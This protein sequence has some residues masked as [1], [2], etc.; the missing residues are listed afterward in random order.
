[1][2]IFVE[3]L[4][5]KK[6]GIKD[7]LFIFGIIVLGIILVLLSVIILPPIAI[8]VLAGVCYGAYYLITSRSLEFE[9]SVTNGDIT[10]DKIIYQR[11]RKRVI[12]VDAHTVE[13]MGKYDAQK[14]REKSFASRIVASEREDGSGAWYFCARD[15]KLGNVL[16]V[17][18]PDEKT[19]TAIRPFLPRQVAR[20]AFD[21][22]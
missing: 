12:S 15:S 11:K 13:E 6:F 2:D 14:L 16:V 7:Y 1:M 21:R 4:I 20:D 22:Y 9:Y 8:L 10:V 17:F 19:L 18:S 5:K 3:Q